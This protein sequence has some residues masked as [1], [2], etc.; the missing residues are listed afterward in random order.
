MHLPLCKIFVS[1]I[2]KVGYL[3][4]IVELFTGQTDV[5]LSMYQHYMLLYVRLCTLIR[6]NA[7]VIQ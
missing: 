6:V 7:K 2:V 4:T 3:K 5:F 1:I